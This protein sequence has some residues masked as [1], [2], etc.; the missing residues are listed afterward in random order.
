MCSM[1]VK[2]S[3]G[4]VIYMLPIED[5][6]PRSKFL[7]AKHCTWLLDHSF[8]KLLIASGSNCSC[9]SW[10]FDFCGLKATL[11]PWLALIA[12]FKFWS[13]RKLSHRTYKWLPLASWQL[14]S[15]C[16]VV[17][18]RL[19]GKMNEVEAHRLLVHVFKVQRV[20]TIWTECKW[21]AFLFC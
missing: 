18:W 20:L 6:W 14:L 3:Q 10:S 16:S 11:I 7:I 4:V 1:D 17:N 19:R 9:V 15:E 12:W 2:A 21:D 8:L 13:G 5:L